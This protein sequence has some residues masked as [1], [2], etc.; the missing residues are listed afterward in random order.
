MMSTRLVLAGFVSASL[1][2]GCSKKSSAVPETT[3]ALE[4]EGLVDDTGSGSG[5]RAGPGEGG[6]GG[7]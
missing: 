7:R 1:L 3:S 5:S 4:S 6:P 2:V